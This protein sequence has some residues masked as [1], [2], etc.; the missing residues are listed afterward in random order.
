MEDMLRRSSAERYPTWIDAVEESAKEVLQ[1]NGYFRAVVTVEKVVLR[2]D[3]E[4][5]QVALDIHISEGEKYW[6]GDIQ[7]NG[8]HVFPPSQLRN[9]IP[10]NDGD[11]FDLDKIRKGL[12]N[13][14]KMYGSVGYINF[15]ASPDV[16]IDQSQRRINV[17]LELEEDSQFRTG[18]VQVLGLN[19]HNPDQELK[20]KL[21]PGDVFNPTLVDEFLIDNKSA[22][23]PNASK[24]NYEIHQSPATNTVDVVFDFRSCQ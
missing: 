23:P 20:I 21:K 22:L 3:A 17:T 12:E 6:L 11:V 8:A 19:L 7:I 9:Q 24:E 16:K 15:T 4:E 2:S 13:L 5:D 18:R 10:L 1:D 14:T